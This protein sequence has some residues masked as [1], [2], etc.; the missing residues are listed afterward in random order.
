MCILITYYALLLAVADIA[1]VIFQVTVLILYTIP[2][3]LFVGTLSHLFPRALTLTA[4]CCVLC[5]GLIPYAIVAVAS[6]Y[7]LERNPTP[8]IILAFLFPLYVP[9]GMAQISYLGSTI[10]LRQQIDFSQPA[11]SLLYISCIFNLLWIFP[12]RFADHYVNGKYLSAWNNE[13]SVIPYRTLKK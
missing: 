7:E 13:V 6:E 8:H 3:F 12:L 5:F 9:Y 11:I 1:T 4:Y 10:K 2:S